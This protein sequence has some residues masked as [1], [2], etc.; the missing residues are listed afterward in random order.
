MLN[1]GIQ[2]N[3]NGTHLEN[4]FLGHAFVLGS[5][6]S[7]EKER[8]EADDDNDGDIGKI[9]AGY[10]PMRVRVSSSNEDVESE[11]PCVHLVTITQKPH[12]F[13]RIGLKKDKYNY[14]VKVTQCDVDSAPL[15][16]SK[17][18]YHDM[19]IGGWNCKCEEGLFEECKNDENSE[20]ED[21][22][23][24]KVR[25]RLEDDLLAASSKLPTRACKQLKESTPI[26]INKSQRYGPKCAPIRGTG[27]CFHPDSDWLVENGMSSEKKGGVE[28]YEARKYLDDCDL[29]YGAGGVMIHEL[30]HA[31]H[32]K[33]TKDGYD[34]EE[35]IECYKNAMKEK[36]Y[37]CVKIH[38]STG[39]TDECKAYA[40]TDPM[41]YFAELSVAFLGGV[42]DD[43]DLEYNKWFPFNCQQLKEH[44]PRA[45]KLLLKIWGFCE[46]P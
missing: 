9:V 11:G 12:H 30:S 13:H 22:V 16:T 33:F 34:N 39:G 27:M 41:E 7:S 44:D 37:D 4:T 26:W 10:R 23:I 18:V 3:H 5:G 29:W 25:Q 43:K 15:D 19:V 24:S 28:L 45:Y 40:A 1:D 14:E 20:T 32:N 2:I 46:E 21:S 35:I 17:K 6:P 38:N 8:N 36:F 42:G 31:W